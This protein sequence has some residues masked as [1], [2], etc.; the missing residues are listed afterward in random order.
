[1]VLPGHLDQ[2][3]EQLLDG[4]RTALQPALPVVGPEELRGL[5]DAQ[6]LVGVEVGHHLVEHVVARAEV[7]VEH[8]DE[9]AHRAAVRVPEVAG[10]HVPAAV[11]PAL[12]GEAERQRHFGAL[13]GDRV[14]EHVHLHRPRVVLH[15]PAHVPPG[16]AQH[17]DRLAADRQEHV[18]RRVALRSPPLDQMAVRHEVEVG[19][20]RVD[21]D[22]DQ[23]VQDGEYEQ[24][25]QEQQPRRELDEQRLA[26]RQA[27]E[28]ERRGQHDDPQAAPAVGPLVL[29]GRW[30]GH[31]RRDEAVALAHGGAGE[32]PGRLGFARRLGDLLGDDV[33]DARPGR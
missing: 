17:V 3:V 14:V 21:D 30:C 18:D 15:H 33:V 2:P 29:V 27:G 26:H 23:V 25:D 22:R 28:A 12:V 9:L 8:E 24:R 16:V 10:L 5:D 20:E 7:R 32:H 11:R 4:A 13:V 6:V 1:V 31:P 19:R